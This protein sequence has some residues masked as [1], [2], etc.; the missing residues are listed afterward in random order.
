MET[1]IV[2]WGFIGVMLGLCWH[3]IG[4]VVI[5]GLTWDTTC[6]SQQEA[7]NQ[8]EQQI[9]K[10]MDKQMENE[11][12]IGRYNIGIYNMGIKGWGFAGWL[13]VGKKKWTSL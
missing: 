13:L 5:L 9:E 4:V 11:M 12:Q 10:K 6:C 7:G 2:Y 1:T 8:I 3:Y